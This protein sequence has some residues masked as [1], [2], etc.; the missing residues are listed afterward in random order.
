LLEVLRMTV[1]PQAN[2]GVVPVEETGSSFVENALLKAR[3][4]ARVSGLPALADDSG[5]AVDALHGAPGVRSAR[6]AGETASDADNI[7]RLLRDLAGVPESGRGAA[8]HCAAVFVRD[9]DDPAP[10]L[11]E[12]LWRGRILESPCGSGGFGYDP[13]FFDVES[14]TSAAC[15]S[16]DEKNRRSHRGRALRALCD[17]LARVLA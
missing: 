6:Y 10:L 5:L 17:E 3:H 14:G 12:G 7:D 9:A 16:A 4:A 11:A 8:F 15:M 13:V 2:A 1:V